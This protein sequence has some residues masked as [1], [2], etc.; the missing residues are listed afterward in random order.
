M[1]LV[2]DDG[3]A[4]GQQFG[5][6]FVAQRDVGEEEVVIDDDDIGIERVLAGL[7]H[8][9]VAIK[10]AVAAEAVVAGGRDKRPDAGVFRNV[11]QFGAIAAFART[12]ERDDFRQVA[13][14]VARRQAAFA[15]RALEVMVADVVGA[16][17]E[18]RDGDRRGQRVADQRQ[19]A[20]EQLILKRLGARRYDDLAAVEQR[21]N[22]IGERLASAGARFRDERLAQ[23][24]CPGHRLRHCELL[25]PEAESGQLVR[26]RTAVAEDCRELGVRCAGGNVFRKCGVQGVFAFARGLAFTGLAAAAAGFAGLS[27]VATTVRMPAMRSLKSSYGLVTRAL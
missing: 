11:G 1:R 8:E 14:V 16:A 24:D 12:R 7:H 10:R 19:V 21:G 13:G 15:R 27:T 26:K 20:F 22:E 5:E 2:E 25:R 17:L 6:A 18:Q 23:R 9:A 4:R 3:I